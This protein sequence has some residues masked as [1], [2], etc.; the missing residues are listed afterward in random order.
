MRHFEES[1]DALSIPYFRKAST[2][3]VLARPLIEK[4]MIANRSPEARMVD[5]IKN[6]VGLIE[7]LPENIRK[8]DRIL[9]RLDQLDIKEK[10]GKALDS[11]GK[12]R[13]LSFYILL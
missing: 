9:S 7:S 2:K 8:T 3:W 6:F 10:S 5:N 12:V 1:V 13:Y 11:K 4:W